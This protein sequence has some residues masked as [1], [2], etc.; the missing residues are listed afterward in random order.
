M[1]SGDASGSNPDETFPPALP[2]LPWRLTG[3][4]IVS[5]VTGADFLSSTAFKVAL[6]SQGLRLVNVSMPGTVSA[7]SIL[8]ALGAGSVGLGDIL[9]LGQPSVVYVRTISATPPSE[10]S[11]GHRLPLPA[12]GEACPPACLPACPQRRRTVSC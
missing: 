10:S 9:T 3:R 11:C 12:C 4:L 2:H 7:D 5:G 1:P 8:Q 6:D